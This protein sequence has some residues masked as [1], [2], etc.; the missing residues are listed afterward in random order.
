MVKTIVKKEINQ[1]GRIGRHGSHLPPWTHQKYIYMWNNSHWKLTGNW[2]KDSCT[3]KAIRKIHMEL[4]R[5]GR[6][7]IRS[8]PMPLGGDSEEKGEHTNRR[9]PWGVSSENHNWK[10]QSW[11][12][13]QGRQAPSAAWRTTGTNRRA[14]GS[15]DSAPEEHARARVLVHWL[16][17]GAGQ[18][19]RWEDCSSGCQVS[20]NCLS[21]CSNKAY[22]TS[23][24]GMGSRA[25]TTREKTWSW[26]AEMTQSQGRA[27]VRRQ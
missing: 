15:L 18:R 21:A 1:D 4:G 2:Q 19:G 10:P 12:P 14:G 24:C 23:Q 13:T 27:C 26:D 25:A 20:H 9:P 8:G 22:S 17:P 7:A 11:H 16:A 3:T 5:K 6:K